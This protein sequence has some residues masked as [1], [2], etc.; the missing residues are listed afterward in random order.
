MLE[1]VLVLFVILWVV[2]YCSVRDIF[3]PWS[4]TLMVWIAVIAGYLFIDHGLYAATDQFTWGILLWCLSFCV[5]GY[6]TCRLTPSYKGAEWKVNIPLVKALTAIAVLLIPFALYKAVSFALMSGTDSL[7]YTMRTQ[8]IE[9]DSGFSLG[10]IPYFVFAV[11][12]ILFISADARH[13][14]NGWFFALCMVINFLFFFVMMSKLILFIGI[15]STLYLFYVHGRVRLR[16]IALIGIVFGLVGLLFT[17][18]RATA[19]ADTD[20]TYTMMEFFGIY[21]ISPIVAFC[22]ENANSSPVWGYETFRPIYHIL[23]SMGLTN[24][25]VFDGDRFFISVPVPTNVYTMMAPLFNDFG[26]A[27]IAV[28]GAIEAAFVS[29]IYKKAVTGHTLARNMYAYLVAVLALQFFDDQFFS[30]ISNMMQMAFF[31]FICHVKFTWKPQS[32][33]LFT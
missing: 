29:W 5:V 22:A 3:A 12:T 16:T 2:L 18:V 14:L 24:V 7:M 6:I 23:E 31:I 25:P 11:Y 10:P 4:I 21:L 9:K 1:S 32:T 8:L 19:D 20:N 30:G 28:C 27:G 33:S 17:Q 26:Y 15:F 13:K